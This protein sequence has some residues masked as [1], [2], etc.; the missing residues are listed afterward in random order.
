MDNI[1]YVDKY[2]HILIKEAVDS[3]SNLYIVI[4]S[5]VLVITTNP[6]LEII[7]KLLEAEL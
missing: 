6:E 5:Q 3:L 2:L 4:Y 1:V 7:L